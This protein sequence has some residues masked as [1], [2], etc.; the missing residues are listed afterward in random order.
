MKNSFVRRTNI[1]QDLMAF[2]HEAVPETYETKIC[3]CVYAYMP[4]ECYVK[5]E[6]NF[7]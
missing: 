7:T 1:S 6:T 3:L 4:L 2:R 5:E